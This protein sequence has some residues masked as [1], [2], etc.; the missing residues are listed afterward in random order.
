MFLDAITSLVQN[1]KLGFNIMNDVEMYFIV[2]PKKRETYHH[3]IDAIRDAAQDPRG[4]P[5]TQIASEI[6]HSIYHIRRIVG[7]ISSFGY[8]KIIQKNP[9]IIYWDVNAEAL[10]KSKIFDKYTSITRLLNT[11]KSYELMQ[12]INESM[13]NHEDQL[14]AMMNKQNE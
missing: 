8:L 2:M 3:I 12:E 1:E 13:T 4:K 5:I 6:N 9:L 7:I 10:V 14:P 11:T